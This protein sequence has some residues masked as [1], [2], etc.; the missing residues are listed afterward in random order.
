MI[1]CVK[2]GLRAPYDPQKWVTYVVVGGCVRSFAK[3][4]IGV[5]QYSVSIPFLA[6]TNLQP[7]LIR[8]CLSINIRSARENPGEILNAI[9]DNTLPPLNVQ[10]IMSD[11][12]VFLPILKD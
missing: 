11:D 4:F 8:H 1:T 5:G 9:S 6:Q 2:R 7:R 12:T 10:H 3:K